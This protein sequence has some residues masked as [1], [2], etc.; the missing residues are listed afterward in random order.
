MGEPVRQMTWAFLG[1][2]CHSRNAFKQMKA[3]KDSFFENGPNSKQAW[4]TKQRS[5]SFRG[6]RGMHFTSSKEQGTNKAVGM[7][8]GDAS[9]NI[10]GL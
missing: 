2:L 3:V 5:V 9:R 7:R 4:V 10:A 1:F 6:Q 8:Y